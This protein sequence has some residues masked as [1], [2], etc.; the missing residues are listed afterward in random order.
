M[1]LT[2]QALLAEGILPAMELL[3]ASMWSV[4]A[5]ALMLTIALQETGLRARRQQ[6]WNRA[7]RRMVAGPARS[8]YQFELGG[9]RGVLQHAA[10]Q[11][12][13]ARLVDALGYAELSPAEL[14]DRM[15]DDDVLASGMAR[16]NLFWYPKP[17]PARAEGATPAYQY[18]DATWRPGVK[19]PND[20]PPHWTTAWATVE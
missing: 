17:L 20:W 13:A 6:V 12:H 4:E 18:Y 3:P 10:T 19:R 16:L 7:E 9:L 11:R 1:L 5:Y 14:L 15:I 2:P 8:L